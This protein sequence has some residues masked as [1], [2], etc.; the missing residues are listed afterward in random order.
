MAKQR[1]AKA[2][3]YNDVGPNTLLEGSMDPG[4]VTRLNILATHRIISHRHARE[5]QV[6][7]NFTD[8]KIEPRNF[9]IIVLQRLEPRIDRVKSEYQQISRNGL[10]I[11]QVRAGVRSGGG[12]W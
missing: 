9:A 7:P 1:R 12:A 6:R 11:K 10:N 2:R 5:R 3:A 4:E 8:T